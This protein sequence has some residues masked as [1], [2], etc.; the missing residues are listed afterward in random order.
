MSIKSVETTLKVCKVIGT[1]NHNETAL[2][3]NMLISVNHNQSVLK[4]RDGIQPNHNETALKVHML[5]SSNHNQSM[6][7]ISE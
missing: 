3:V 7:K 4:V 6:L 5:V 1:G 2:K